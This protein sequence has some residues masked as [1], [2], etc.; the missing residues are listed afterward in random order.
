[1]KPST[2]FD[3]VSSELTLAGFSEIEWGHLEQR[4]R[5]TNTQTAGL[6][7]YQVSARGLR[8]DVSLAFDL[9]RSGGGVHVVDCVNPH[10]I[11]VAK[12]DSAFRT[13]LLHAD[14]LL[15]DGAGIV[16]AAKLLRLPIHQ[17]VA[18]T[19]FFLE[20]SKLANRSAPLRYFFLGSSQNVLKALT[21]KLAIEFPN[22]TICGSF[23]PPFKETF[24]AEETKTMVRHINEAMPDVLW[25]GMTAPKQEKWI[26][27][28]RAALKVPLVCAIGATFDF[29][30]GAKQRAPAWVCNLGLEWLPRL[31]R[32]PRR[33]WRRNLVSTPVFMKDVTLYSLLK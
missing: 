7:G 5:P 8:G 24:T 31:V 32:E 19:E 27:E 1:M 15:P 23:S 30:S 16:L 28:N 6:L 21:R 10:S 20:L 9:A 3:S 33:L 2:K 17:R 14:I 11:V 4:E 26:E 18:G 13:A 25:V 22:I 29:Y 12:Q